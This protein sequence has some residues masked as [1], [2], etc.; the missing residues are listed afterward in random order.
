MSDKDPANGNDNA[1]EEHASE[2]GEEERKPPFAR[3]ELLVEEQQL[4][5]QLTPNSSDN[6]T[7]KHQL[8][9]LLQEKHYDTWLINEDA[10]QEV[11]TASNKTTPMKLAVAECVSA[12]AELA[13]SSDKMLCE[14]TIS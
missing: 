4:F 3:V 5:A 7:S 8:Q 6:P 13:I 12:T 2:K 1:P 14:I 10:L 11:A 9:Q